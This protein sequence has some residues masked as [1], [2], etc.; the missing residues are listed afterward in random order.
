MQQ[1]C[2]SAIPGDMSKSRF[3]E[4]HHH[5][6]KKMYYHCQTIVSPKA[7]QDWFECLHSSVWPLEGTKHGEGQQQR[8]SQ[9][10]QYLRDQVLSP[11]GRFCEWNDYAN[12]VNIL[13]Y[14]YFSVLIAHQFKKWM[15]VGTSFPANEIIWAKMW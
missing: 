11:L 3:E 10:K 5:F 12:A 9:E 6:K 7:K 8:I 15:F 14:M 1:A 13:I 2:D 4:N